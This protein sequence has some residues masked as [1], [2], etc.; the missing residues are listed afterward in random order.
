MNIFSIFSN[1]PTPHPDIVDTI[2]R[3]DSA[4]TFDR[5]F[6]NPEVI[7]TAPP[8][9][10]TSQ[11]TIHIQD[12]S[13]LV[14]RIQQSFQDHPTL[15]GIGGTIAG[16]GIVYYNKDTIEETAKK[17]KNT[18]FSHPY[19]TSFAGFLATSALTYASWDYLKPGVLLLGSGFEHHPVKMSAATII[20]S[21]AGGF[22]VYHLY[23]YLTKR[24]TPKPLITPDKMRTHLKGFWSA[25][26]IDGND[27]PVLNDPKTALTYLVAINVFGLFIGFVFP[28]LGYGLIGFSWGVIGKPMILRWPDFFEKLQEQIFWLG[29]IVATYRTLFGTMPPDVSDRNI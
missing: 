16:M 10:T 23:K 20:G 8:P 29:G 21:T 26:N 2:T 27:N 12:A 3:R 5:T 24:P 17:V 18:C 7:E 14:A 6:I 9:S 1:A 4:T 15:Y 13:T 11:T 28:L 22:G 25:K 19:L